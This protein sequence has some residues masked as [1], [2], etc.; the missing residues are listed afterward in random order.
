[1]GS[2]T[3]EHFWKSKNPGEVTRALGHLIDT[4]ERRAEFGA[5][6]KEQING[7]FTLETMVEDTLRV[8]RAADNKKT[9]EPAAETGSR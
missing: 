5:A 2:L 8:Y 6:I 3:S 4:P 7:R 1:M 9:A